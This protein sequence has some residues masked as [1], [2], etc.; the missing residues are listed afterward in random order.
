MVDRNQSHRCTA[1]LLYDLG[2]ATDAAVLLADSFHIAATDRK[3]LSNN[4][5]QRSFADIC[6]LGP[7]GINIS[8]A[9]S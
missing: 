7:G 6:L 3:I 1:V 5:S 4:S 2:A 9:C 8:S